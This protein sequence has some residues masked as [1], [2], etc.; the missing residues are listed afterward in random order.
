MNTTLIR[1]TPE[2][3]AE[4]VAANIAS[5]LSLAQEKRGK[6]TL[7]LAGGSTPA[8]VY[9]WLAQA[10]AIDWQHVHIFWGDERSVPPTDPASNYRMARETL[11]EPLGLAPDASNIHRFPTEN[12][13][14]RNAMAY[15]QT[16]RQVCGLE[17]GEMPRFD[18]VL[19]GMG[20]DGHTASL[21]PGTSALHEQTKIAVANPVPAQQTTRLTLTYPALNH[22]RAILFLIK[23]ASKAD[24]LA[25]IL[26]D[27]PIRYPAQGI[28]PVD[29]E[30]LWLVDTAAGSK[31][32]LSADG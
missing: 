23:G 2:A 17:E 6:A 12:T 16:I 7:V 4:R 31:V 1:F 5:R 27:G 21:F 28:Q 8:P 24:R 3:W 32:S 22:A 20:G 15:E 11:F 26:A 9:R 10:E 25:E 14:E 18:V 13:P 19:L 30:L 29:G